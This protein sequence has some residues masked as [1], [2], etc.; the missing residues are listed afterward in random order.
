[1]GEREDGIGFWSGVGELA[2]HA[3]VRF[4]CPLSACFME[5]AIS[6]IPSMRVPV[7]GRLLMLQPP[8]E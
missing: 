5:S 2:A 4:H 1:M 3:E 6:A 8:F 7:L